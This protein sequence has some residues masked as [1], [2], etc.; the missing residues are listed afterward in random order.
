MQKNATNNHSATSSWLGSP[1]RHLLLHLHGKLSILANLEVWKHNLLRPVQAKF[2]KFEIED[3]SKKDHALLKI[4]CTLGVDIIILLPARSALY[5]STLWSPL[6][7]TLSLLLWLCILSGMKCMYFSST[8]LCST[9]DKIKTTFA[10][11]SPYQRSCLNQSLS[12]SCL[13]CNRQKKKLK[14][15]FDPQLDFWV[16]FPFSLRFLHTWGSQLTWLDVHS[17]K[18]LPRIFWK[19]LWRGCSA[20]AG[21]LTDPQ[22]QRPGLGNDW[23]RRHCSAFYLL[24]Y[25]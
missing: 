3:P 10:K 17:V 22:L 23:S 2:E 5:F 24:A 20:P 7:R 25:L 4:T 18:L 8:F 11:I 6:R 1:L 19:T 15:H 21:L 14:L 16:T 12:D 13:G 9:N